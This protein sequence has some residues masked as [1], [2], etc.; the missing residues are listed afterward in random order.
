MKS[1]THEN[2]LQNSDSKSIK[3]LYILLGFSVD[4]VPIELKQHIIQVED[5]SNGFYVH[6]GTCACSVLDVQR[7]EI[8]YPCGFSPTS[9]YKD[10]A[11]PSGD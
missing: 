4:A 2:F 7:D 9:L 6:Y 11:P 8:G 3:C 1:A 5:T 10:S